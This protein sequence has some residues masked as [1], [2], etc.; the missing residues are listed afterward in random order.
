MELLERYLQA[1]GRYLPAKGRE[2]TLAELR[3]NLLAEMEEREEQAGRPLSE[4]E[5]AE[6]LRRHGHPSVVA[7][8][9]QPGRSLIGPEVFPYY[10]FTICRALPWVI[11]AVVVSRAVE[12]IYLPPQPH[13]IATSIGRLF[14]T[15]FS[16]F[17][18]MTLCFA[19]VDLIR[20]HYPQKVCLY[21]NWDPRKLAKVEPKEKSG[22]PKNPIA[23]LIF[24]ALFTVW[25]LAVPRHPFLLFGPGAWYIQSLSLSLAPVWHRFYW[26]VVALNCLQLVFKAIALSSAAQ[27]WRR[28]MKIVEQVFG[29]AILLTLLRVREY[30]VFVK[31]VADPERLRWAAIANVIH[32][33]L[34]LVA[35]IAIL[36]LLWDLWQMRS[37]SQQKQ[38]KCVTVL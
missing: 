17:S 12:L 26:A 3:A 5:V 19:L 1:V 8:R 37:G 38:A 29:I 15:L 33:S 18:L 13:V 30:I 6:V 32:S 34:E 25:L 27:P 2:D 20:Q 23:D 11:A 24:S 16:Y 35:V 22:L 7:A 4:D 31:P 9:Y 10:W 14:S 36:K 28:W 21:A